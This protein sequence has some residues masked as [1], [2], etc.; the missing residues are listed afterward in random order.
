M[1]KL[2]D[3]NKLNGS[4]FHGDTVKATLSELTEIMGEPLHLNDSKVIYL[5]EMKKDFPFSIYDWRRTKGINDNTEVDWHIGTHSQTKS[6]YAK[7]YLHLEL[8]N[9]KCTIKST[10]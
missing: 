2:K 9:L 7:N 10:A 3:P 1:K 6:R 4:S 8:I 5:W